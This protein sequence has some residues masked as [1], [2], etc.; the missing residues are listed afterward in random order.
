MPSLGNLVGSCLDLHE[1]TVLAVAGYF[2]GRAVLV[3]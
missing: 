3:P 1:P 2:R